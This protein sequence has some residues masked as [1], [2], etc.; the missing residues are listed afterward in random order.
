MTAAHVKICSPRSLAQ[1]G[2]TTAQAYPYMLAAVATLGALAITALVNCRLAKNAEKDNPPAGHFLE[3]NGV[4][5]HYIERGSGAPLVL[6]HGNG[7]V[8]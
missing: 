2:R 4:R 1:K 6:L 7:S 5:L 3:V 8:I